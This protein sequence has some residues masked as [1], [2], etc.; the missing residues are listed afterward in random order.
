METEKVVAVVTD[1]DPVTFSLPPSEVCYK[2]GVRLASSVDAAIDR[3]AT[4]GST[5]L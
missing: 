5:P 3:I 4:L 2:G 1:R